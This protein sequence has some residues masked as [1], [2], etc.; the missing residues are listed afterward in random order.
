P[1]L[2]PP[3]RPDMC[4]GSDPRP[5]A[6]GETPQEAPSTKCQRW[7]ASC[8][9]TR[10]YGQAQWRERH[11]APVGGRSEGMDTGRTAPSRGIHGK[12][13]AIRDRAASSF[14]PRDSVER[15]KAKE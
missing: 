11:L 14:Q 3:P 6:K 9:R 10:S 2:W 12:N 1:I 15:P 5:A 7:R 8:E 13:G 4:P